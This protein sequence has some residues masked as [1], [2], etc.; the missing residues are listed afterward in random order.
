M[1]KYFAALFVL[2]SYIHPA[3]A[4]EKS[5]DRLYWMR[6]KA[7]DKFERSKIADL[8]FELRS[9]VEDSVT[10]V[11][12]EEDLKNAKKSG[13]LDLFFAIDPATADF[14]G[15]DE[16]FHTYNELRTA[17]Q[18]LANDNPELVKFSSIGQSIEG[19]E[20]FLTTISTKENDKSL[21]AVFFYGGHHAREHVSV[22]T[23]LLL[24]QYLVQQYKSGD[25]RIVNL[26]NNR[27]VY[28]APLV[29][30]DGAEYDVANGSY[31]LWRKNRHNNGGSYGVDLNRNYGFGWG[32][33][34][35]STNPS[36]ETYRGVSA[37][38]EPESQAMKKFFESH[39]NI[40]INLSFHTFSALILYP[41]GHKYDQIENQNDF[42]VHKTMA[43]KMA[44]WNGYTP[45]QSSELYI[46]SGD[47][48]DWAYGELG[49]ISFTFEL[50]PKSG[51]F[52]T[53]PEK[54]FY[55]GQGQ[56][57]PTFQKNIE[58]CLYLLE[59]ADNPYRVIQSPSYRYGLNSPLIK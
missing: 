7:K 2:I 40:S 16:S 58:P 27:T 42:L 19:R 59:Y 11:G 43:E 30:P 35:A 1:T 13:M 28:I 8:G 21:P 55:P 48:T 25:A 22:E 4:T 39:E 12:N 50:D 15:Y 24:A 36:N 6:F 56:I 29:N 47:T 37:F 9:I 20:I 46:A 14:P 53:P 49:L 34:G 54:G 31:R 51:G 52:F 26:L 3:T 23:P 32:G 18:N 45:Q 33:G 44:G 57:Q 41:W 38:S 17:M 5:S 10:T